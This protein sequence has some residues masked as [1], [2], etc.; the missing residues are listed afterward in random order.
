MSDERLKKDS[1]LIR[2]LFYY[3]GQHKALFMTAL[4]LYPVSALAIVLP[5]YLVQQILDVAIPNADMD[6]LYALSGGYLL[7]LVVDYVSGLSSQ[8]AMSVLGQR[9]MRSLRNDLFSHMQKLPQSYFD[10]NPI[11]RTLTRL[12]N[13]VESLAEIFAT[14]AVTIISDLITIIAIV[15]AMLYLDPG[16]TLYAFVVVPPL[17][18]ATVVVQRFAREAFRAVRKHLSRIN[19]FLSEHL[20]GMTVVQAFAQEARTIGAFG[21]LNVAYRNA[22]HKA[23]RLDASLFSIVEAM[24]T[25]AVA[26]LVFNGAE[27]LAAGTV[28]AG[29]LVAFIQYIRRFFIPIRDLS[30]KYTILQSAFAGAERVFKLLEEPITLSS[31]DNA[32]S[33]KPMR[34]G[35]EFKG[36]DFAYKEGKAGPDWVL[37][38]IDLKIQPGEKVALVGPTG[39]GKTT[40][41]K[42]LNRLYD[43]QKGSITYDGVDLKELNLEQLRRRFAVVLQD[44]YLFSGSIRDNLKLA[45]DV[46]E[47]KIQ[48]AAKIVQA[49]DF[50]GKLPEGYDTEVKELGANFSAGERQLLAFAR[51]LVLDPDILVLDEATSNVDSETEARLQHALDV[52][53][54]GRT[55]LIV[56][57]RLSTIRKVDRIVVLQHGKIVQQ[58]SHDELIKVEGLYQQLAAFQFGQ[59]ALA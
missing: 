15:S 11:G 6:L 52:L 50:I 41:L 17:I 32:Q 29:V 39:S 51:A 18:L 43:V 3:L 55:A 13:D 45:A 4:L 19:T 47:D 44:V 35:L 1:H 46:P 26:V 38:D 25:V 31:A 24:G 49:A 48:E 59:L 56:A 42:L 9:S 20:P 28:Q 12:T 54:E 10:V 36:V 40:I 23:I 34:Q 8:F 30:A 27:D 16:M 2:R 7:A 53:L 21:E 33:V 57:H 58:G 14:G 5:P 22:N 37:Q